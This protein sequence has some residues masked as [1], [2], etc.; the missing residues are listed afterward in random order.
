MSVLASYGK[1]NI[2]NGKFYI[3]AADLNTAFDKTIN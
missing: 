1:T 2:I 3:G